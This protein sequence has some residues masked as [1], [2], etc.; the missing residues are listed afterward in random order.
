MQKII[1]FLCCIVCSLLAHSQTNTTCKINLKVQNSTYYKQF[2]V[3]LI[4]DEKYILIE[5]K[6]RI[7]LDRE[8]FNKD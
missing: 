6:I 2:F 1:S 4:R 8:A 3:N 5:Y 7:K